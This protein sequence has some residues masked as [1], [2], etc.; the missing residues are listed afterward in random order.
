VTDHPAP[1]APPPSGG[2]PPTEAARVAGA[3]VAGDAP[4][5]RASE[6]RIRISPRARAIAESQRIDVRTLV[7]T[8]PDGRIIER[9][10]QQ[11]VAARAAGAVQPAGVDSTAASAAP[12]P[13]STPPARQIPSHAAAHMRGIIARRMLESLRTTAQLTLTTEVD[14]EETVR[15]RNEVGP[16]LERR[17]RVHVTYTDLIVRAAAVALREHQAIN[18]RWEGEGVHRLPE[19]HIGVAVAL[20]EGLVVPVVRHADRA[21]IPQISAAIRDLSERA[22]GMRLR[23]DEMA[24]HTFTVTNLGMFDVDAFTPVLNLPEAA[25]LGVGRLHRRPVAAGDR[26]EIHTTMV[27]SLTF[28]HRVVDGAPAAQFLQRLKHILEHP[29]LLLLP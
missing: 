20:E 22:R 1:A 18:A 13:V 24:G 4:R 8:G 16:E 12:Q 27:L 19:I 28:D 26:A 9:D 23:P 15:L 10:V 25:M 14:M 29:Y 3:A 5:G 11:A 17:E 7:G 21:S 2:P 6:G